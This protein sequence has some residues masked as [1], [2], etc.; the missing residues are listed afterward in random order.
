V[1]KKYDDANTIFTG[2]VLSILVDRLFDANI[3]HTDGKELWD[4][5]TTKYDA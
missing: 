3:Q 5:L 4:T 1:E 2:V